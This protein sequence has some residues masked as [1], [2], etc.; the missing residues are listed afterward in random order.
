MSDTEKGNFQ[1]E[2]PVKVPSWLILGTAKLLG[3]PVDQE[4]PNLV[5]TET[6]DTVAIYEDF[7]DDGGASVKM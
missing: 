2:H 6:D 4:L 3:I 7:E 1:R 5:L